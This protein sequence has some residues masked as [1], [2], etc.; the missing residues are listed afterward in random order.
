[1]YAGQSE[2][3]TTEFDEMGLTKVFSFYPEGATQGSPLVEVTV[4]GSGIAFSKP[5]RKWWV[6]TE[7]RWANHGGVDMMSAGGGGGG[8]SESESDQSDVFRG[9]GSSGLQPPSWLQ[10]GGGGD[11]QFHPFGPVCYLQGARKPNPPG[12]ASS[13]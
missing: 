1:M 10:E 7:A 9:N 12:G 8:W 2:Q 6:L 4:I 11:C 5:V 3:Y 13:P